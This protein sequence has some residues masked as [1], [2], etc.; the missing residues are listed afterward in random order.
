VRELCVLPS[1]IPKLGD[2]QSAS[3]VKQWNHLNIIETP[4]DFGES[5][6]SGDVDAR[7]SSLHL[8]A[9]LCELHD[10]LLC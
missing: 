7:E 3:V 10:I 2:H 6:I 5:R 4:M 9:K 8:C 1:L